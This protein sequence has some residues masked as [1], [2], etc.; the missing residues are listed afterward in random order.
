MVSDTRKAELQGLP[1]FWASAL[2][3][4]EGIGATVDEVRAVSAAKGHHSPDTP[5][6]NY[7]QAYIDGCI[8]AQWPKWADEIKR[9]REQAEPVPFD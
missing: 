4:M 5:A 3:L 9:L 6:A 1:E 7:E 8:V 2:Q